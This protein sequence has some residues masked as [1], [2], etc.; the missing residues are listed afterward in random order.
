[1]ELLHP[2]RNG[3]METPCHLTIGCLADPQSATP[4][5]PHARLSTSEPAPSCLVSR[6]VL[7]ISYGVVLAAIFGITVLLYDNVM[8]VI[9]SSYPQAS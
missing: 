1:M 6:K 3:R 8:R 9:N 2:R 4:T 5:Q 7:R